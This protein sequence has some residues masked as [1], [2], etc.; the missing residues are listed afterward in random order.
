[1]VDKR[2]FRFGVLV[3]SVASG[4]ELRDLARRAEDCGFSTLF[5]PDHFVGYQLAPV[6]AMAM[7]AESTTTLRV[8]ALVHGNDYRHPVSL[9][10]EAATIDL[11]SDGRLELGLGAGW[12]RADYSAT[13]MRYDS[14]GTRIERLAES[15]SIIKSLFA[16]EQQEFKG[17]HYTVS[18]FDALPK[19]VQRPCPPLI[20][21]GGAPRILA[22]AA[23]EADIVGIS[24]NLSE[25]QLGDKASQSVSP[26]ATD[27]K[28]SW[29][30]DAAGDRFEDLEIQTLVLHADVTDDRLG[31]VTPF[32]DGF[33]LPPDTALDSQVTLVGTERHI[34]EQLEERRRRWQMT[35][36]VL[37]AR[38]L[39][40]FA[41]IVE[42][43]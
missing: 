28:L 33:G 38:S 10:K 26:E 13:G 18:S 25:G 14:P 23:R 37:P 41:P 9:A 12:M 5:F 29:V 2:K 39:E 43:L 15:V 36:F 19:P 40:A 21:G 24:A 1:M 3:G 11:L 16:E 42:R 34:I 32:A 4:T 8:G 35:Y 7:A 30:R 20:L 6:P 27:Q 31:S 17:Q 22:L